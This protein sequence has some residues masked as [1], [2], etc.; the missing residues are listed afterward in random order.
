MGRTGFMG[1]ESKDRRSI[2][3]YRRSRL[4]DPHIRNEL[5][6]VEM[7]GPRHKGGS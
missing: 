7:A 1:A 5:P 2:A 4:E 6:Q 3:F